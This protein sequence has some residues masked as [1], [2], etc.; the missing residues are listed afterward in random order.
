MKTE[1]MLESLGFKNVWD[2]ELGRREHPFGEYWD[3]DGNSKVCLK[4]DGVY[5]YSL[6]SAFGPYLELHLNFAP[7]PKMLSIILKKTFY[8]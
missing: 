1:E 3:K 4:G 7:E 8:L 6:D 5:A 2:D